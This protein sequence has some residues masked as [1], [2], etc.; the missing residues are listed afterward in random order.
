MEKNEHKNIQLSEKVEYLM[1][2]GIL[3][4]NTDANGQP[5]FR[6][7]NRSLSLDYKLVGGRLI[8]FVNDLIEKYNLYP[9][10]QSYTVRKRFINQ[11]PLT[12]SQM[13]SKR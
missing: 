12:E 9:L 6:Y 8:D 1:S 7:E 11:Y 3:T 4:L 5:N 2:V 13:F 10:L